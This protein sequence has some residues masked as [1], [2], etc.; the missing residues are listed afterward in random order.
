MR[1]IMKHFTLT[2]SLI[3]LCIQL[4]GQVK[5]YT[6]K[7]M[8]SDF[9]TS[10]T[11]MI[12]GGQSPLEM[13]LRSEISSRWRVSPFEFRDGTEYQKL[14][15]DNGN[16]LLSLKTDG[17][18]VFIFLEKG[19]KADNADRKKIPFEVT[20]LPIATENGLSGD[21]TIFLS[22]FLDIIQEQAIAAADSDISAYSGLI[23]CNLKKMNGKTVILNKE[24]ATEAFLAG[25]S[26]ILVPVIVLSSDSKTCYRM[27]VDANTHE[28]FHYAKGRIKDN[29]PSGFT[30]AEL[31]SF[32]KRHAELVE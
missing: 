8:L 18:V 19:G 29:T 23:S 17:G 5:L 28:L 24:R 32:Q 31:K 15:T 4:P 27:L 1:S 14:K 11:R 13:A 9:T 30:A 6:K 20:R 2:A 25:A 26:D 7:A 16:Y 12:V 3:L 21:E 10:P 22:A